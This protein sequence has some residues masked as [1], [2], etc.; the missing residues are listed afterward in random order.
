M[1]LEV[2]GVGGGF[3][4]AVTIMP[5]LA[6]HETTVNSLA[7]ILG[8]VLRECR[9]KLEQSK[10]SEMVSLSLAVKDGRMRA[11]CPGA[12]VGKLKSCLCSALDGKHLEDFPAGSFTLSLHMERARSN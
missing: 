10:D 12:D 9:G 4:F 6:N 3:D 5:A 2:E 8:D 1:R 7:R 11:L